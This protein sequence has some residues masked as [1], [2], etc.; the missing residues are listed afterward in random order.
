MQM[1]CVHYS[2]IFPQNVM[3]LKQNEN[4]TIAKVIEKM[5]FLQK[6]LQKNENITLLFTRTFHM[7]IYI[8]HAF[9]S[10]KCVIIIF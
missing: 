6:N 1:Y 5:V 4:I 7:F 8:I 3:V 10:Y 9:T 2:F